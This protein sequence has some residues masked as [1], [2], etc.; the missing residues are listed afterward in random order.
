MEK[1]A[2]WAGE[3]LPSLSHKWMPGARGTDLTQMPSIACVPGGGRGWWWYGGVFGKPEHCDAMNPGSLAV[4]QTR[5]GTVE[6][7]TMPL[8]PS[9]KCSV[10]PHF[11]FWSWCFQHQG[12]HPFSRYPQLPW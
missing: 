6:T 3:A 1:P 8:L 10:S 7:A 12:Q 5:L 11:H 2:C 9:G 4:G